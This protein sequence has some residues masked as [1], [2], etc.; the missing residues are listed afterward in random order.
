M[1]R[2]KS[3][4]AANEPIE[5]AQAGGVVTLP[6]RRSPRHRE[7]LRLAGQGVKVFPLAAGTKVPLAGS[8]AFK[9]AS[10]DAAQINAWFATGD[11]NLGL[12]PED[13][14]LFVLDIDPKNGGD[15][16]LADLEAAHGKLPDTFTVRTPSGGE[17]HYFTGS[18]PSSAG[19]IG[20]GLDIRG[21]GGYVVL[22]PSVLIE[23]GGRGYE[24]LH[25]LP[26]AEPAA[27]LTAKANAAK[28]AA[29]LAPADIELDRPVSLA[30]AREYVA[31]LIA[32]GD[33]AVEGQG[34]DTRTYKLAARMGDVGVSLETAIEICQ[35][36]NEACQPPWDWDEFEAK[37]GQ[38]YRSRQNALVSRV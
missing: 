8:S 17:H 1:A 34:G 18:L 16:A 23:Y 33:V 30:V 21:V 37:I 27:W 11:H 38:G 5:P 2:E 3:A 31:G 35:P 14:G 20:E 12:C 19:K 10:A 32:K 15:K 36:W 22:P 4:D 26:K 25:D 29:R 13:A 7:A 28:Q 9:D 24:V 6:G